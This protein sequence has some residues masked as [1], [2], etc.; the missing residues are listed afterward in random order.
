MLLASLLGLTLGTLAAVYYNS[1]LDK[2]FLSLSTVAISIPVFFSALILIYFFAC[3]LHLLPAGGFSETNFLYLILPA[4]TL[5][6]RPTAFLIR[7]TRSY[8]LSALQSEYTIFARAKGLSESYIIIKHCLPN[9]L[10]PIITVIGLDF[11][12]YLNG[13]I[14]TETIFS[15]PGIGN[16]AYQA[17]LK[18]DIPLIMGCVTFSAFTFVLVNLIVDLIYYYVNPKLRKI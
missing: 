6:I 3:F 18:R 7:L 14:I 11:G 2:F 16:L 10:I 13:S 4:L 8:V 17:I 1:K 9:A 5:G 15:W 12:N